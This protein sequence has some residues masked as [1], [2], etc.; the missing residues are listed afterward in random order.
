M[1]CPSNHRLAAASVGEDIQAELHAE[2]CATCRAELEAMAAVVALA[3]R[4][5]VP[6]LTADRRAM[7]EAAVMAESDAAPAVTQL[8][9]HRFV[10]P[11]IGALSAALAAAA[12]G[13]VMWPDPAPPAGGSAPQ[14]TAQLAASPAA[15][16][17]DSR[18]EL[19]PDA[20]AAAVAATAADPEAS[21]RVPEASAPPPARVAV[22]P[23]RRAAPHP[24]TT[25]LSDGPVTIDARNAA[26]VRVAAGD[27]AV[28]ISAS[29][30]EVTSRGGV[31]TMVRVFA[32]S[33]EIDHTG[34]RVVVVAGDVWVRPTGPVEA[35]QSFEQGWMALRSARYR[36]AIAAFERAADPVVAEDAAYWAAIA[37]E[38]AGDRVDAERRL[39]SFMI[40]F[41]R[42]L[43]IENA[44][45]LLTEFRDGAKSR[46]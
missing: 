35:L 39:R 21:A 34:R 4:A 18:V 5:P 37:A 17:Q 2:T 33:A 12:I 10:R 30:V 44:R 1:S 27:T 36:D 38:R 19:P 31:V 20:P 45:R 7:L 11:A 9:R 26:P 24:T 25:Q 43:R 29:K 22:A 46:P 28:Q 32:G 15:S 40:H 6:K 23:P 3:R 42:S 16:S 41:P 8:P 13:L 14:A